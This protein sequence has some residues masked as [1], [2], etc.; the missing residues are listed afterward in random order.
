LLPRL[1]RYRALVL[2]GLFAPCCGGRSALEPGELVSEAGTAAI[3]RAGTAP[4]DV[5]SV[6]GQPH[7]V[8]GGSG[9][10]A[11]SAGQ[12]SQGGGAGV[13]AGVAGVGAEPLAGAGGE[14]PEAGAAGAAGASHLEPPLAVSLSLGAFHSC[15]LFEGGSVRC[16]GWSRYVGTGNLETIGDDETPNSAGDIDVGGV[17]KSLSSSWYHTCAVLVGGR[18]RC[19]GSNYQGKLGYGRGDAF[20]GDDESPASAGD[21]DVG[22]PVLQVAAGPQHTCAVLVDGRLRCWGVNSGGQLGFPDESLII[23]DDETPASADAIEIGGMAAQAVAG[24]GYSCVLLSTGSVRCWGNGLS[25]R[26]QEIDLGGPAAQIVGGTH[27]VCARL[28]SGKVRCWGYGYDG[29]LGYGND[30]SIGD[31]EAVSEAGDVDVGPDVVQ[32]TAGDFGTCALLLAGSVRCWGENGWGQLGYGHTLSVGLHETPS[33]VGDV[34]VG[35][36]V[37][38]VDMGYGHSCAVLDTG[39]VRCWGRGSTGALGY[40]NLNDIG[41]DELP[42]S[43]GDV[44]TH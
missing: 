24:N 34:D 39:R 13:T 33:S 22:G 36:S 18:V 2:V 9:Q 25:L 44:E 38:F 6:A 14:P 26:D 4:A 37:S 17:V 40:G 7:S 20:V 12:A 8:A 27:H 43:A 19:W 16:W 10:S 31:D 23:G 41:D 11:G 28:V 42:S 15:A 1:A 21:V 35:G 29:A 30:E 32:L 5:S 3:A